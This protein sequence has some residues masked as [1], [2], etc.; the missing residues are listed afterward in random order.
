MN[1]KWKK[2]RLLIAVTVLLCLGLA[3]AYYSHSINLHALKRLSGFVQD[4]GIWGELGYILLYTIRPLLLFPATPLTLFGGYT[5]GAFRGTIL[6]II[7]AG[8]GACLAFFLSRYL[9]R[10]TVVSWLKNK[11]VAKLDSYLGNNGFLAVLY[12]RIIPFLPFDSVNYGMGITAVKARD[13]VIATYL[14]IIPGAFTLNFLGSS[15]HEWNSQLW[16]AIALYGIMAIL[17]L[18]V[19]KFSKRA[20]D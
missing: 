20:A 1:E 3:G 15:L 4:L 14:G 13:Y 6:D 8:S 5:F 9:G 16:V 18:I 17:P 10:E 19:K 2:R 12:L 7:G 11:K